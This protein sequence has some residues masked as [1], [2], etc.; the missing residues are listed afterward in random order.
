[1]CLLCGYVQHPELAHAHSPSSVFL[2]PFPLPCQ[3]SSPPSSSW[4]LPFCKK[5]YLPI[6]YYLPLLCSFLYLHSILSH[7][8][9]WESISYGS[10]GL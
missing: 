9:L 1:M 4:P 10:A 8:C 7:K 6:S 3:S 2:P 5:I